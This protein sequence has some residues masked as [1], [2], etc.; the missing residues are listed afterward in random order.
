MLNV[1]IKELINS[2]T[3]LTPDTGSIV[4]SLLDK[5]LISKEIIELDFN[6]IEVITSA[7]L[8]A[9]IGQL[10][11]KFKSDELNE[12][13]KVKNLAVEDRALLRKVISRAKE[14]F[15]DQKALNERF[16]SDFE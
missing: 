13:L 5:A 15:N 4:F 11:S 16:D 2:D 12:Y 8:N 3:A 14:Y 7:F 9:A 10:Y 6:G 1:N